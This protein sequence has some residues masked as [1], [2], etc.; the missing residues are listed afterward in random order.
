M[1][2][3]IV[4]GHVAEILEAKPTAAPGECARIV[5]CGEETQVGWH[6]GGGEC[7]GPTLDEQLQAIT[8]KYDAKKEALQRDTLR[9]LAMDG[10]GMDAA[11]AAIRAKW[12]LLADAEEEE[13]MNLFL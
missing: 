10:P 11:L 5:E 1:Y 9:I 6:F 8:A 13:I 4:Q 3:R 7:V 2:A 12:P